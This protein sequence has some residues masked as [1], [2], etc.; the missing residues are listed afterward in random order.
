MGRPRKYTDQEFQEAIE[1]SLSFA[2]AL[3]KVGLKPTGGNY[4]I[5]KQRVKDLKLD[6]S[7]FKGQGYL[8]GQTHN[9][10]KKKPLSEI[11]IGDSSYTQ[12]AKIRRKLLEEGLMEYKCYNCS[13]T[14]WLGKPIPLELEHINGNRFDNRIENLTLICP[15]C[16]AQTSTY[17]GKNKKQS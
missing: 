3:S 4:A 6:I 13:G 16:H 2:Q 8:K 12:T 7:H 15:N 10:G 11:L 9:W 1:Q 14:E 5:A 17:R